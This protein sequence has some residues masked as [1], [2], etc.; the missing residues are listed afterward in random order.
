MVDR[1]AVPTLLRAPVRVAGAGPTIETPQLALPIESV[2][3]GPPNSMLAFDGSRWIPLS[4]AVNVAL[5]LNIYCTRAYQ[6]ADAAYWLLD[7][8]EVPGRSRPVVSVDGLQAARQWVYFLRAMADAYEAAGIPAGRHYAA[9][10]DWTKL[11]DG[12]GA[13]LRDMW[14]GPDDW[15]DLADEVESDYLSSYGINAGPVGDVAALP[16][17]ALWAVIALAGAVIVTAVTIAVS[18]ATAYARLEAEAITSRLRC[19]DA[20]TIDLSEASTQRERDDAAE[21]IA[22][23]HDEAMALIGLAEAR[24]RGTGSSWILWGGLAAGAAALLLNAKRR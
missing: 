6:M 15:R 16:A 22:R 19:V 13:V 21:T 4:D 8:A 14:R 11:V 9:G 20:A 10:G 3:D 12:E 17:L 24:A 2:G 23:C 5:E 1:R 18:R 7:Y